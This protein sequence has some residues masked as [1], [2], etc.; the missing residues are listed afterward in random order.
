M[1]RASQ[2]FFNRLLALSILLLTAPTLASGQ[3]VISQVYAE[4]G[5]FNAV[6]NRDFVELFNRGA[7]PVSVNGWE[8]GYKRFDFQSWSATTRFGIIPPGG[9]YL[10]ALRSGLAGF[11]LPTP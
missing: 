5:A 6:Y 9:Y 7:T 2:R 11:T 3:V 10:V 4:G 8:V 1:M